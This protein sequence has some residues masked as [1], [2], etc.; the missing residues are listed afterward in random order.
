MKRTLATMSLSLLLI[1]ALVAQD[2][3]IVD[4]IVK[5]GR[6]N[7][8]V[9]SHLEQLT[10]K[11]GPRLTTSDRCV[12]E[13]EWAKE[14][15]E[16]WGLKATLDEWNQSA[17]EAGKKPTFNVGFNRGAWSAKMTAPEEMDIVCTTAA[18]TP[19]TN[20][21]QAGHAVIAPADEDEAAALGEKLKG[22]WVVVSGRPKGSALTKCEELGALGF[23][24][25][26]GGEVLQGGGSAPASMDRIP[27]R[28]NITLIA[29]Q[30][31]KILAL[32]KDKNEV[33]LTF[34]I[35][36]EFVENPKCYNVIADI[37]G[38]EKP[39]EYVVV[40][41]HIDS[42][43]GAQGATDN[44]TGASTTLEA[45]RILAAVGAKPKR[46]IRFMLWSGE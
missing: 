40:G 42:W 24:R 10:V 46:T 20:G 36:N 21:P 28:V 31:K 18:W 27:K 37:V 38:S 43:D 22:A 41:G 8:K 2:D 33:K 26:A 13:C 44:G 1:P 32:L 4:K 29:S 34:D 5:E 35:K 14:Q 39:D 15:L 11:G 16:Q 9:M 6:E 7:S 23:L 17:K 19:G 30:Y 45:A 12:K 25:T 3:S